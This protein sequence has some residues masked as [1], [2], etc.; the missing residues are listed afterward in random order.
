MA[1]LSRARNSPRVTVSTANAA[2][3][4]TTDVLTEPVTL[5]IQNN[6][7]DLEGDDDFVDI[8]DM[9]LDELDLGGVQAAVPLVAPNSTATATAA[10][11]ATATAAPTATTVAATAT[12]TQP[13]KRGR[14]KG[15]KDKEP[16]KSEEEAEGCWRW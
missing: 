11:I 2:K 14:P 15:L 6:G 13:R 5:R 3:N 10:M 8:D 7:N 1:A 16:R 9:L 12:T 4:L